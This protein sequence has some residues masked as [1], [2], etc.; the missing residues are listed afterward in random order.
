MSK[1]V[2]FILIVLAVSV[3]S[4]CVGLGHVQVNVPPLTITGVTLSKES[5]IFIVVPEFYG[6]SDA[7]VSLVKENLSDDSLY[8]WKEIEPSQ[9]GIFTVNFIQENRYIGSMVPFSP[10]K[11][12][13][14]SRKLFIWKKG[15][16]VAYK[17]TIHGMDI[18]I[19]KAN[20]KVL[21]M[22]LPKSLRAEVQEQWGGPRE[23]QI[24]EEIE[25]YKSVNW[26]QTKGIQATN[27]SRNKQI[28]KLE[29]LLKFNENS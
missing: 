21:K 23:K 20:I 27:L 4:S 3:V 13:M 22:E 11:E 1:L 26:E 6:S 18:T 25:F 29:L 7:F 9:E 17:V 5:P 28:D 10:S 8:T 14:E 2:K 15:D 19:E 24:E 16:E 12:T